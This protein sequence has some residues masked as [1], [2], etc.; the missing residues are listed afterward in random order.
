MNSN[1][2][3]YYVQVATKR[4]RPSHREAITELPS[5]QRTGVQ[6]RTPEGA[7]SA[8]GGFVRCN[9]LLASRRQR[10]QFSDANSIDSARAVI[11]ALTW[12]T[13]APNKVSV[14]PEGSTETW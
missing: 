4:R 6:R 1:A 10:R 12:V 8:N 13:G 2:R 9:T 11:R 7:R 3:R 5:G 14:S